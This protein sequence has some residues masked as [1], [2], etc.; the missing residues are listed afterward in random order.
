M[1][2]VSEL[3][4]AINALRDAIRSGDEEAK[5][6][7]TETG[8]TLIRDPSEYE[9]VSIAWLFLYIEGNGPRTFED[10]YEALKD[11]Q[12]VLRRRSTLT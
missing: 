5:K 1:S 12:S 8:L 4:D 6:E 3:V 7:A 11:D 2:T 10:I 9:L